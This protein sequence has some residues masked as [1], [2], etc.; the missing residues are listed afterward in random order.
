MSKHIETGAPVDAVNEQGRGRAAETPNEI[1]AKGLKDVLYRV[2]SGVLEDRVT[3]IAAGVTYYLLLALF[4]ALGALVS[5]YGFVAD[6]TTIATHIGFL[7]QL[8]PRGSFD[9]INN[10]L[11]ALTEQKPQ[12][13]SIGF[14]T[15]LVIALWSANNGIKALCDAMNV[16]Y[17]EAESR[18]FIRYNLI[19]L[20]FTFGAVVIAAALIAAIGVVPAVLSYLW[21][22]RWAEIL[23]RL[24]RWPAILGLTLSGIVL[25]YRYGPSREQ[26][27]LRWL[28]WG[29][30]LTTLLWLLASIAFS[31]YLDHFANYNATYGTLGALIA[32]MVWVWILIIILIV[33]A[34]LNA[35]LEHQTAKDS[36]VGPPRPMGER[37]A[38]VADTIGRNSD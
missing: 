31:F 3:L 5:L 15:G 10:Q 7:S 24:A 19:S 4:P 25:L 16:A 23:I 26:A 35:E 27:K 1:P 32:F 11:T 22:D 2:T 9:L 33:G 20:V 8:F 30:A 14:V 18:G 28:S 36:T 13:L 12:T 21:L 38:H 17:K 34:E 6:T 37:G 29:A